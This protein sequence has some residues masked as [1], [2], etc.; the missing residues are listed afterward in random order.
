MVSAERFDERMMERVDGVMGLWIADFDLEDAC[1][2]EVDCDWGGKAD[3]FLGNSFGGDVSRLAAR[4]D[5]VASLVF[6]PDST[7]LMPVA[8]AV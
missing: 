5:G 2:P 6:S 8:L 4:R 7:Y 3:N 1:V